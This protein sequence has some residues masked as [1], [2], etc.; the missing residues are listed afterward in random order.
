MQGRE[1]DAMA[2]IKDFGY[3]EDNP[4]YYYGNAAVEFS[5]EK[6]EEAQ[7]WL[8]SA[9][10]IYDPGLLEVFIDSFVEVGW[11]ETL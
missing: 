5:K 8:E 2:I 3:L 1:E 10:R 7:T 4:A 6:K 11:V 9:K